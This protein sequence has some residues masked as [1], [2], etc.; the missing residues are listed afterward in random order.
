MALPQLVDPTLPA[1]TENLNTGD[2]RIRELK[3]QYNDILGIPD[4]TNISVAGFLFVAGGLQIVKFQDIAADPATAGFLQRNGKAL[5]YNNSIQSLDLVSGS[6]ID[7]QAF[8]VT[9]QNTAAET[10]LYAPAI[11]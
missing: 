8:G 5:S 10:N 6:I 1:G 7:R 2:D 9:V 3:R 4:A 11:T